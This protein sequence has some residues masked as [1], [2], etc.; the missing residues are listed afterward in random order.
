MGLKTLTERQSEAVKNPICIA[1]SGRGAFAIRTK[2]AEMH[3]LALRCPNA[4]YRAYSMVYRVD[5]LET[6]YLGS[7]QSRSTTLRGSRDSTCSTTPASAISLKKGSEKLIW[8]PLYGCDFWTKTV[9]DEPSS[10]SESSA[11][12]KQ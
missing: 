12:L 2:H 3:H 10:R 1:N 9:V 4:L 6:A 7:S 11:H 8:P 5:S